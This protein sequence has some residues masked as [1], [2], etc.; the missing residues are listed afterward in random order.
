ML[1]LAVFIEA[2]GSTVD[3]V[4]ITSLDVLRPLLTFAGIG[5]V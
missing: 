3:L 1:P 2:S 5:P 4:L